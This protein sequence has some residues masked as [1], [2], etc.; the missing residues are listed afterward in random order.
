MNGPHDMGGEQNYGPVRP[1][2]DEPIFHAEWEARALALTLAVGAHGKWNIDRSRFARE[3]LSPKLYLNSTYYER[4]IAALENLMVEHDL[5]T[6]E[7]LESGRVAAPAG[8]PPLKA[9]AVPATL[10]AGAPTLREAAAPPR[11]ALGDRVCARVDAP[12]THTRLPR[13]ARG[14]VGEVVMHHG[15]HVFADRNAIE[16]GAAGEHL[17]AVR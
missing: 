14:R 16:Y 13:Y 12:A 4:W 10:R 3:Q 2:A 11:F 7:E 15:C 8:P 1:E 9:A 6:R 5:L 17:Y